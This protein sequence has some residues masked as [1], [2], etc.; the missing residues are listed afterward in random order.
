MLFIVG[1]RIMGFKKGVEKMKKILTILAAALAGVMVLAGCGGGTPKGTV[2]NALD[3][4]KAV[5]VKT[6]NA[7]VTGDTTLFEDSESWGTGEWDLMKMMYQNLS[8][9]IKGVSQDGDTATVTAEIT[10]LDFSQIVMSALNE[11]ISAAMSGGSDMDEAAI[12]QKMIDSMKTAANSGDIDSSTQTVDITL[13]KEG[14]DWKMKIDDTLL[15]ALG[16]G[17]LDDITSMMQ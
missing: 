6:F 5:D 9:Q 4:I 16:G 3:S 2:Q 17:N 11:I 7:T 14:S 12:A 13:V 15:N 8:Y 1:L 10:N